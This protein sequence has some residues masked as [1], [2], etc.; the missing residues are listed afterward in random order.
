MQQTQRYKLFLLLAIAVFP[1]VTGWLLYHFRDHIQFKTLNRGTLVSPAIHVNTLEANKEGKKLWNI[2]YA[3]KGCCDSQCD[4]TM[5]TLHQLRKVLGKDGQRVALTLITNTMC[6]KVDTHDFK[7]VMFNNKQYVYLQQAIAPENI[8][9][10]ADNKIYL[11]DP[12]G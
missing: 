5:F 1:A 2:V 6:G 12:I 9:F 4:K 8:T 11:I 7:K 10:T 3:P